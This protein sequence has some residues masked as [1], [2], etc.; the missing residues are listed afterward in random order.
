MSKQDKSNDAKIEFYVEQMQE[1]S[2]QLDDT[3]FEEWSVYEIIQRGKRLKSTFEK[4]DQKF[5]AKKCEREMDEA[6]ALQFKQTRTNMENLY[7]KMQAKLEM[8]ADFLQTNK[9]KSQEHNATQIEHQAEA[10]QQTQVITKNK[11]PELDLPNGSFSGSMNDWFKFR[12]EINQKL[13]EN[14][15]LNDEEKMIALIQ[16]C[17]V[18]LLQSIQANGFSDAWEKLND[19][20]NNK[21]KLT[22][23]YMQ[24]MISVQKMQA[25]SAQGLYAALSQIQLIENAFKQ[26]GEVT[27][28]N[29]LVIS[30][31]NKLDDETLRAWKRYQNTLA[32]S[33]A[34]AS[35]AQQ[36]NDFMP[37]MEAFRKFLEEEYE[38]YA[39]EEMNTQ[40]TQQCNVDAQGKSVETK[41]TIENSKM[42]TKQNPFTKQG[43]EASTSQQAVGQQNA[44]RSQGPSSNRFYC[45][46]CPQL[47]HALYKC[48]KF[49]Y[50]DI[51]HRVMELSKYK[52]C[53]RCF[54]AEHQGHCQDKR[55][56]EP[57]PR[58][59]PEILYHNST[60]C[61]KNVFAVKPTVSQKK[62]NNDSD[63]SD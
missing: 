50:M 59:K 29:M 13:C 45:P 61:S 40:F 18:T 4:C 7:I 30:L 43:N 47:M 35:N 48:P 46:L 58:C 24:K 38:M 21:F 36:Q 12:N 2:K 19:R 14:S 53:I 51:E 26:I 11:I 52:L 57:C 15:N 3:T 32:L 28:D 62:P 16:A 39:E 63:W 9:N 20:Y 42:Q 37:S 10:Q 55:S 27:L 54:H 22:Q 60:V 17:S 8:R 34:Q 44:N 23:F 49:L 41:P 1:L 25:A 56:N 31:V 6:E 33:W 5:M